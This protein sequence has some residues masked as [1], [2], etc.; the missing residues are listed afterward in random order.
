MGINIPEIERQKA[1]KALH[2]DR[3]CPLWVIRDLADQG[4]RSY[5]SAVTPIADKRGCGRIV[6]LVPIADIQPVNR[7]RIFWAERSRY[8]ATQRTH[9]ARLQEPAHLSGLSAPAHERNDRHPQT[10]SALRACRVFCRAVQVDRATPMY[11]ECLARTASGFVRQKDV[12]RGPAMGDRPD[13]A[14]IRGMPVHT[15]LVAKLSPVSATSSGRR[16]ICR[17]Q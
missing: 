8:R 6:R 3:Q 11:R 1:S 14:E 13:E 2:C 5:L 16:T 7:G 15:R 12:R 10:A 9:P 4:R 17:R